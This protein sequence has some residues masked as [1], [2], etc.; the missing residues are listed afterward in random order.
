MATIDTSGRPAYMYDEDTDTWYAI[1]GR[2]STS[3]NYVWTGAQQFT[4]NVLVD[5]A[6]TVTSRINVFLNP[7]ARSA[8]ITSPQTGLLTFIRQDAGGSTINRLEF[9]DGSAWQP[10]NDPAT[11]VT[12]TGTQTLTNKTLTS[13]VINTGDI[14]TPDIDGGTIDSAT[15]TD[16]YFI[17]PTEKVTV[18][19]SAA[20]GTI[21]F[22]CKNNTV[23]Y[24]TSNASANWTMNFRGDSSTT[25]NTLLN[26]GESISVLFLA[27]QGSTAY[28]P[29]TFQIDGSSVTPKWSGGTAPSGGNVNSIDAYSFS[30][31]KTASSTYTVIAGTAV[32]A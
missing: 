18:S 1:S 30:I 11:V 25:L 22:D 3:A 12:L 21:N 7:A 26:N 28:Y 6:L 8:A 15:I 4:N 32:F 31:I 20:S 13:P 19:A 5:G 17:S 23:L 2:V 10:Y 24:Y 9:W 27:T 14:N 29:T 16:G